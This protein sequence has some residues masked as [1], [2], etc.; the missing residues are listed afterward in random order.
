MRGNVSVTARV[1]RSDQ[2]SKTGRVEEREPSEVHDDLG[3]VGVLGRVQRLSQL[4]DACEVEL[5]FEVNDGRPILFF[6]PQGER[7][8]GWNVHGPL[9]V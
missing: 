4:R 6:G 9:L 2:D 5:T 1:V 7:S 8:F 3:D